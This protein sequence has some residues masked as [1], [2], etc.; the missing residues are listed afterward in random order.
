[1]E[2]GDARAAATGILERDT[3]LRAVSVTVGRSGDLVRVTIAGRAPG[4][5]RGTT[6]R[7]RVVEVV[8][9]EG[10]VP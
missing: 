3:D 1:M 6:S 2:A 4:I 5:L 7:V 10:V 8:P 9:V